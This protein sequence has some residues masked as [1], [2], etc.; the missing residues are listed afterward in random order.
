MIVYAGQVA[1]QSLSL[2]RQIQESKT[3]SGRSG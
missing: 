2:D 1:A 3:Y